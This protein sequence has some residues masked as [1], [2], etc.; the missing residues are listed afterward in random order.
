MMLFRV[1]NAI[2]VMRHALNITDL[3]ACAELW[4]AN[5]EIEK[6]VDLYREWLDH[7]SEH[8]LRHFV[9]YNYGVLLTKT[10][11]QLAAHEA[12]GEAI[13]LHPDFYAAYINLGTVQ[14]SLGMPEA[15]LASWQQVVDRLSDVHPE[16]LGYKNTACKQIGRVL[17]APEV[18]VVLRQSLELFPHQHDVMEHWI[19]ARQYQCKWPLIQP[20]GA[21][22][23][24]H[25]MKGFAPLALSAYTD[26]PMLLLATAHMYN[27]TQIGQPPIHFL[28]S[29]KALLEAPS[30]RPRIAYISSDF[31]M[32]AIG[33]L[34]TEVFALHNRANVE[35]FVYYTGRPV[36]DMFQ[37]RIRAA[38]EHWRDISTLTDEEAAKQILAD[39]IEIIVDINGYTETAR[40]K[41]LAMRPAPIIV[42]WLGY[43]GTI[44]SPY[45]NYLLADAFLVPPEHEIFYSETVL[46]LPCYQPND[47][48]RQVAQHRPT[49]AEVG[50]PADV[51]VYSCFNS[52]RKI[53]AMVWK[54]W[55]EILRQVPGSVLWLLFESDTVTMHLTEWAKQQGID[56]KRLIFAPMQPNHI[57][58][59]RYPLA[60]L[61]LDTWP[62]GAHT[63]ASDALWMGVP[64]LTVAGLGFA[65]RV[66]GSLASAA[67]MAE[68]ICATHE[69]YVMRAVELGH[70]RALLKTYRER[71]L[72]G[73]DTCVLF[74]TPSLVT[75][76]E[77]LF[78]KMRADF[79]QGR[80][81]RP[82]LTNLDLYQE[83]GIEL[84]QDGNRIAETVQNLTAAYLEKLKQRD[85]LCFIP[86]DN[87]LWTREA[88]RQAHGSQFL[89]RIIM[90]DEAGD[91]E[92]LLRF[93]QH[94]R[95][96]L[97]EMIDAVAAVL[98]QGRVL[99]AYLLA[100][101]LANAG[102][103]TPAISIA[104]CAGGMLCRNPLE[105]AR[106][107]NA[108]RVQVPLLPMETR[109]HLYHSLIIP[110]TQM[111]QTL[112]HEPTEQ[113]PVW[114]LH[115]IWSFGAEQEEWHSASPMFQSMIAQDG[116]TPKVTP[117]EW[118]P[119]ARDHFQIVMCV[120]LG[121]AHSEGFRELAET[122]Q[123]GLQALGYQAK[124]TQNTFSMTDRNII[125]GAHLMHNLFSASELEMLP[126]DTVLYN[127][128]Q[129]DVDSLAMKSELLRF[130]QRYET[131]DYSLRNIERLRQAGITTSLRYLPVGY[132]QE[133]TRIPR[134][135]IEDIDVLF[136]GSLCARRIV[137]L[138]A[139]RQSGV[140]VHHA[141]GVYGAQRD[142]LISRAKIILNIHFYSAA[143]FES[144]R[145]SYLLANRKA[146]V[147]ECGP[148]T[149]MDPGLRDGVEL[150]DYEG[151]VAACLALLQDEPR[152]R[153]LEQRG[154]E[155]ISRRAE[156]LLLQQVL[157]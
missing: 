157:L 5:G 1:E 135:E 34:I 12:Y 47:R 87:R 84:D 3:V 15:A 150:A 72:A 50:L 79:H 126:A 65:S 122:L 6:S 101:L 113:N 144:V 94:P 98:A 38:A 100:M 128:E 22:D 40:M 117:Q 59:A 61:V 86:N 88:Q 129:M 90:L 25:L 104:L 68:L 152:R 44:G 23:K 141:F 155:C 151:V 111:L 110:V 54:L 93:V 116:M 10:G 46:R 124:I 45:H 33:F 32:H 96:D 127:T 132:V 56:E 82:D 115:A 69:E 139:L 97:V 17:A 147:A 125:L 89:A 83:I 30:L 114:R 106:G 153:A 131:W 133:L 148:T 105:E 102:Q 140:V 9:Y 11:H 107:W 103:S 121:S 149:E 118:R 29:H 62:Y 48:Q 39:R 130:I 108:L 27:K 64:V 63:T 85:Q 74:D 4:I 24:A 2:P 77:Q 13:R 81:P 51:M 26:D 70:N 8:P 19:S 78:F 120:A 14:E 80:V 75:H 60:D 154:F 21:C 112:W 73:R 95:H 37:W 123:Y 57:H 143:I 67:G 31:R 49:R 55:C 92:A 137:I 134:A 76:L 52:V 28:D 53:T 18:E 99:A 109:S 138:D 66:C 35:I 119:R 91:L 58:L 156:P 43:P 71:V 142:A 42:N 136:Y 20:V 145:V 41:L 36:Q 16:T 7:N 146:V